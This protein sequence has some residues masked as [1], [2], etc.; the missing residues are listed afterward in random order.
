MSTHELNFLKVKIEE[1]K[2]DLDNAKRSK[3]T[4]AERGIVL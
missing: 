1:L 3:E 2:Q 4:L